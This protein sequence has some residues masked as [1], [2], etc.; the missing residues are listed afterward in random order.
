MADIT[1]VKLKVRRG[2]NAQRKTIVLDQG[3]LGYTL[4]TKRLFVGDGTRLGGNVIG[5]TGLGTF[6]SLESLGDVVGAQVGD[7]G[8]ANSMLWMLSSAPYEWNSGKTYL[9][10]GSLLKRAL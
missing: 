4:D 8:Y 3:E 6:T 9:M 7:V 2:S 10:V 1:I 5:N